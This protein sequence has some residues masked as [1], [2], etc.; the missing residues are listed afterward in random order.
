MRWPKEFLGRCNHCL[1]NAF[2]DDPKCWDRFTGQPTADYDCLILQRR[3]EMQ[4]GQKW[5]PYFIKDPATIERM[6]KSLARRKEAVEMRKAGATLKTIAEKY[7]VSQTV[8]R[9]MLCRAE[10]D[11]K[12]EYEWSI[13]TT[14]RPLPGPH[15]SDELMDLHEYVYNR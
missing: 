13:M 1:D 4:R 11:E 7:G 5:R 10:R 12:R 9:G 14:S 15:W 6:Q 8:V 3:F 2:L